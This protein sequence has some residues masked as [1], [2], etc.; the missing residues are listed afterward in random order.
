LRRETEQWLD[1]LKTKVPASDMEL[2][3]MVSSIGHLAYHVGA[4]RQ[5]NKD[6]RGP[7]EGTF[8]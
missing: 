3:G 2:T 5:I 8:E 7:R 6:A 4:I 1:I